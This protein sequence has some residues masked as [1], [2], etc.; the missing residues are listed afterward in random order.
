MANE[1]THSPEFLRLGIDMDGVLADFNTGWIDRYNER[2]EKQLRH[3][4]VV[5]WDGLH[6]L[7]HFTTMEA[8]WEWFQ[9]DGRSIFRDLPVYPDSIETIERLARDH[10]V[11]IVSSKFDWAIPDT[12][13]WL[14]EHRV[15]AREIHF[16]HD[17]TAVA[18]DVYLE[19]APYHLQALVEKRPDATVC[20]MVRPWNVPVPGTVNV[21]SW[22]QFADLV[23]SLARHVPG[24]RTR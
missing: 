12:L 3:T 9:Q 24:H 19:D 13:E 18:C 2:F 15:T 4:D 16:V 14:A 21:E 5:Q 1:L 8:F 22:D 6:E 11:V 20:R 23:D 10:R 17:K 7:T